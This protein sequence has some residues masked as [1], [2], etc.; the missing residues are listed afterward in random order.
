MIKGQTSYIMLQWL[1]F[2]LLPAVIIAPQAKALIDENF[3]PKEA[4]TLSSGFYEYA[5]TELGTLTVIGDGTTLSN[6]GWLIVGIKS[7][8]SS[9]IVS[10]GGTVI[11]RGNGWI[12]R[13]ETSS[14]NTVLV[15]DPGSTWN[16]SLLDVGRL[17]PNN[18][19]TISNG[20]RVICQWG[21]ISQNTNSSNN[22]V[23]VTGAGSI[24]TNSKSLTV[25][26]QDGRNSLVIS[27]GGTVVATEGI[28]VG[29]TTNAYSNTV[30]V[31]GPGSKWKTPSTYFVCGYASSGNQLAI[32]NGGVIESYSADIGEQS[33]ASNNTVALAGEGSVWLCTNS[34]TGMRV[35]VQGSGSALVVESGANVKSQSGSVGYF[36]NSS[37]NSVHIYGAG[38]A[39]TMPGSFSVGGSDNSVTISQG[40]VL[41]SSNAWI[42]SGASSSNNTVVVAGVGA[43][44][45][46][47]SKLN[48][49]GSGSSRL[50][51]A[52]G[53][54]VAALSEIVIASSNTSTSSLN[55][56]SLGGT[57]AAGSVVSPAIKFGSGNGAIN[58]N[59][60][61]SLTVSSAISGNGSIN[62]L[63]SGTT[64]L[65]SINGFTG[66]IN[67]TDGR[68]IFAQP[69]TVNQSKSINISDG[70][71]LDASAL[72]D[73][74]LLAAGQTLSGSGLVIGDVTL[75]GGNL[76]ADGAALGPLTLTGNLRASTTS[77]L[78]FG[79]RSS[80]TYDS[81]S[82]EN[83][84]VN[85]QVLVTVDPSYRARIGDSFALISARS[86][87]SGLPSLNLPYLGDGLNWYTNDFATTG[88]LRV[89]N[90][91]GTTNSY[92][93]WL[94][95]Y[96]ALG[97]YTNITDDPDGDGFNNAQ[98]YALGTTPTDARSSFRVFPT[99]PQNGFVTVAWDAIAG[100]SYQVATCTNLAL[101]SWQNVGAPVVAIENGQ[102]SQ[103]HAVA[104]TQEFYRVILL[105]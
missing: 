105:H 84:N 65:T 18:T 23:L 58:F 67:I 40:G 31:T 41:I 60:I 95:N 45:T 62:Q 85:C 24:W 15:T 94:T 53:G 54:T 34:S 75:S 101:G 88:I 92:T 91:P 93:S 27:N 97:V 99:A 71:V 72:S 47:A 21:Y 1:L 42:S 50:T 70:A 104:G 87:V 28:W 37:N 9:L 57:D 78:S 16:S 59:Q 80:S 51:V 13:T 100:K 30:V 79:I 55:F 19:L 44:W 76:T 14:N 77:V 4:V 86:S 64:I 96:P 52:N 38:A 2:F 39:W 89:T 36:T 66:T 8:N 56:G 74:I 10:N 5:S 7:P 35:G 69:N 103:S 25:G 61:N 48:L 32:A 83:A 11:N 46:N 98:E 102:A 33:S 68:L 6:S 49:G 82:V 63:G 29:I 20:G 81:L 26:N 90:S 17:G 73:G 22:S 12:G 3:I 43:L